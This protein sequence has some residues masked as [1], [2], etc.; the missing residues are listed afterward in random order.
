MLSQVH[1][2]VVNWTSNKLNLRGHQNVCQSVED[3][4]SL[5]VNSFNRLMSIVDLHIES[6]LRTKTIFELHSL[7][8]GFIINI[9]SM[10]GSC[11]IGCLSRGCLNGSRFPARVYLVDH[12]SCATNVKLWH[13]K[14]TG[15]FTDQVNNLMTLFFGDPQGQGAVVP[16]NSVS[17]SAAT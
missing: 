12:Q 3:Y 13:W 16:I 6:D 17:A 9:A 15:L 7:I 14:L 1:G 11:W 4:K 2:T 8:A 10:I 5:A